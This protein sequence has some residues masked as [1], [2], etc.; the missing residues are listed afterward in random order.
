MQMK[1]AVLIGVRDDETRQRLLEL[2]SD[3]T[4]EKVLTM[5]KFREATKTTSQ[6]LRPIQPSTCAMSAYKKKK[7][8][9]REANKVTPR[10]NGNST[11]PNAKCDGCG[12]G[13]HVKD[14]C[15]VVSEQGLT[16]GKVGHSAKQ[17]RLKLPMNAEVSQRSCGKRGNVSTM[18][19]DMLST[20]P[21]CSAVYA[22]YTR[23]MD[24]ALF[25]GPTS[26]SIRL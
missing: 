25:I 24:A 7:K 17:C 21:S 19:G 13:P 12:Y 5:C 3:A 9:V 22:D 8:G 15:P 2:L 4:L 18:V 16:C 1:Q 20:P 23:A 10:S 26:L 6:K 14:K 11:L